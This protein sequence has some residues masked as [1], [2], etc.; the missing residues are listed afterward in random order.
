MDDIKNMSIYEKLMH[1]QNELN[2]PKTRV[3]NYAN[4]PFNYRNAEDI[5]SAVKPKAAEYNCVVYV[6][7]EVKII[8][9]RYYI[10]ATAIFA[11]GISDPII[12]CACAR[13]ANSR[14]GFDDAQLSGS[15]SSYARKYALNGLLG[16][17]DVQDPDAPNDT[18]QITN[19][20]AQAQSNHPIPCTGCGK[21]VTAREHDWSVKHFGRILCRACQQKIASQANA[22]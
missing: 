7:D 14:K 9:E 4:P 3:N 20:P 1:V 2:V 18:A 8:G 17:D 13:E 21:D 11:D 15:A 19:A 6:T 12:A 16:L 10:E 5:L 22:K